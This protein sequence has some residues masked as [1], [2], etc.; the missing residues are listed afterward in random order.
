MTC[1]ASACAGR[2]LAEY[3]FGFCTQLPTCK[4]QVVVLGWIMS[5][6]LSS[7]L[8]GDGASAQRLG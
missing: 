2:Y 6:S 4:W 7:S 5:V 3:G 1:I 8:C